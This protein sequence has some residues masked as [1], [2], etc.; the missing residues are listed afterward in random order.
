MPYIIVYF[1]NDHVALWVAA[2]FGCSSCGRLCSKFLKLEEKKRWQ[3]DKLKNEV[4][5]LGVMKEDE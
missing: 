1:Y 2:T 4:K 5:K 3:W